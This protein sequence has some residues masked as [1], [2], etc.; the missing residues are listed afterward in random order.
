MT[1]VIYTIGH[2]TRPIEEFI[3]ML[4]SFSIE[5][6]VDVR[7]IPASRYNPQFKQAALCRALQT[8]KIDYIYMKALG[9][10]RKP[11]KNSPNQGWKNV[12][13]RGYADYMQTVEFEQAL[14]R[15]IELSKKSRLAIMCAE[16]LP[17]RCHRSLIADALVIR[18]IPVEHIMGVGKSLQHEMTG[19]AKAIGKT[20]L[21]P[22]K[23]EVFDQVKL[24][25]LD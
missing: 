22:P 5:V 15:L 6:L 25:G 16:S 9:G 14:A 17:W 3:A 23:S 4:K 18:H 8:E 19:F 13:F 12:S 20:L 10:L 21:Y 24:P 11:M 7:T 1:F 2:S